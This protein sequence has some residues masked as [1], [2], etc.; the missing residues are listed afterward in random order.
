MDPTAAADPDPESAKDG[1]WHFPEDIEF[2]VLTKVLVKL[3]RICCGSK[4]C[5]KQFKEK[6][7]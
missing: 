3:K 2:P 4:T 5:L 1:D 6:L 7:T